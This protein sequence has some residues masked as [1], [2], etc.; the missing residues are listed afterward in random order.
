MGVPENEE[1]SSLLTLEG[2]VVT[3]CITRFNISETAFY[4]YSAVMVSHDSHNKT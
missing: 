2:T 1:S 4:Q 3:L